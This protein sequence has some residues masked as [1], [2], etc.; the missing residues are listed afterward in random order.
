[1]VLAR[2]AEK[3][4]LRNKVSLPLVLCISCFALVMMLLIV[5]GVMAVVGKV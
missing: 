1:M 3:E 2:A 4:K 5:L